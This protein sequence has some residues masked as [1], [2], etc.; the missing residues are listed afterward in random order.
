M[1]G[2]CG[3]LRSAMTRWRRDDCYSILVLEHGERLCQQVFYVLSIGSCASV[4]GKGEDSAPP[5]SS[6][7]NFC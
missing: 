4:H 7:S 5:L 2:S 1:D 6:G 3:V